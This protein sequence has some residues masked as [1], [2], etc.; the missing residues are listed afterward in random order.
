MVGVRVFISYRRD[1]DLGYSSILHALIDNTFNRP[2][3]PRSPRVAVFRDTQIRLGVEWPTHI[4]SQ[5]R[6]ADIVL[7]VIGPGWLGAKDHFERRRID[8]ANDWVRQEI[9][10]ALEGGMKVIPVVFETDIPLAEALPISMRA[11]ISREGAHIRD[12]SIGDD[13]QPVL[14]AIEQ[15][16]GDGPART[17]VTRPR[18]QQP[19]DG[20]PRTSA[21]TPLPYPDPP[22][23]VP[24]A[25]MAAAEIDR[26]LEAMLPGWDLVTSDLPERP[27]ETRVELHRELNFQSFQEVLEFMAEVGEFINN[28]NHHPRWENIYST[29]RVFLS[30]W[31]IGHR[32]SHLDIVLASH[33]ETVYSKYANP[34]PSGR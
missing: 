34:S 27:G 6:D 28:I 26:A 5:L 32:V 8:Q 9:E 19:G 13:L 25:P 22:L 7:V 33:F 17:A 14:L 31:D 15:Q 4:R 10:M 3:E 11:L 24:P 23:P 29:L 21:I 12:A 1:T 16:L 2:G 30:T 18:T 20:L